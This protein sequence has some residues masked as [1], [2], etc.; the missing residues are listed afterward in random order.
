MGRSYDM[1]NRA[2]LARQ[3][4]ERIVACAEE[5]IASGSIADLTLQAIAARAEVSVQTLIRHFGG[6]DGCLEAVA[7]RVRL[8]VAQQRGASPPGDVDAALTGLLEHY[9]RE[10]K[11]VL[12]LLGQES[13]DP[14]ARRWAEYGRQYHRQWVVRCF[15][16]NLRSPDQGSVDALVVATDI[17]VWKL[18]RLDLGRSVEETRAVIE[19]LIAST[20]EKP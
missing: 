7:E 10:G 4:T 13:A 14:E 9:E 17:H 11:L 1:K 18:L 20:L 5:L 3:T 16:P 8:R 6:R 15:G 12:N 19:Q 2:D